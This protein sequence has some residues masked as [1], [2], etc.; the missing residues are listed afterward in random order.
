M[1]VEARTMSHKRGNSLIDDM[2]CEESHDPS[3]ETSYSK[4]KKSDG[5]STLKE[6]TKK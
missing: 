2:E 4:K 3:E 1:E 6:T 5:E